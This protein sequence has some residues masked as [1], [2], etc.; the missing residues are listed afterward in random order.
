[1]DL[2]KK[3][4][5]GIPSAIM[6]EE[7]WREF[8]EAQNSGPLKECCRALRLLRKIGEKW[9]WIYRGERPVKVAKLNYCPECGRRL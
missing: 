7:I 3:Y 5:D 4:P 9:M 8:R 2:D 1:M 6:S